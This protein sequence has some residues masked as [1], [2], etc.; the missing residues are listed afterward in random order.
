MKQLRISIRFTAMIMLLLTATSLT[1]CFD[2]REIDELAYPM[3]IGLDL[4]E[5]NKLR[6]TIQLAAPL[7]IGSG[8]GGEG[9]G[10]GGESTSIITVDT[11]SLYSGLNLINNIISKEIIMSHAKVVVISRKLAQS[12]ISKYMHAL[13]RGREFRSDAFVVVSDNPPDEYLRNVKPT[14]ESNPS[15]YYELILGKT[16]TS[17]YPSVRMHDFYN[18]NESDSVEPVAVFTGLG[19]YESTDRLK[20]ASRDDDGGTPRPEGEYRAGDIPIVADQKNEIMGTA[21][22]KDGKMVGMLNGK[23]TSCFQMITGEY[24]HSYWTLPDPY[25]ENDIIVMDIYQRKKPEIAVSLANGKASVH[26]TLDLEGDFTAIQSNLNYE[27]FPEIIERNTV[28]MMENEILKLLER[29]RDEFNSDICGAGNF[30]KGKF[31]TWAAWKSYN[32][33][34]HFKETEFRIDV[35]LKMRRTGLMIKSIPQ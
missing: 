32:W 3:A 24:N 10:G 12:G 29:T 31:T 16:F 23:E 19:K 8:E 7:S 30:V 33:A 25:S 27:D 26:Y 20:N 6:L 22:F 28:A 21:V 17:F 34:D 15:K 2:Q 18:K 5:A 9:G 14:L 4:G 13:Q 1:G 35:K 11:P